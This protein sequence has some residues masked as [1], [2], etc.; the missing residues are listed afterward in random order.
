MHI[1]D[2]HSQGNIHID[3]G[4]IKKENK[5]IDHYINAQPGYYPEMRAV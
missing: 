3:H 5:K 2:I 1:P 4:Q